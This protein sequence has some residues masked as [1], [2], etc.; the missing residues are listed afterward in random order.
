M[1]SGTGNKDQ[2]LSLPVSEHLLRSA[3]LCCELIG[4]DISTMLHRWLQ[5]GAEREML[6]LVSDGELSTGKFVELLGITYHDYHSLRQ[7]YGIALGSSEE[8]LEYVNGEHAE[9]VG[10]I[11]RDSLRSQQEQ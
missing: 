3:E 10:A 8:E 7:K 5:A 9:A 1:T 2:E 6:K 4:M 11:L